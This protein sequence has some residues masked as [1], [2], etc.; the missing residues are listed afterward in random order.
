MGVDSP[1]RLALTR[2]Q[3]CRERDGSVMWGFMDLL[4]FTFCDTA[5]VGQWYKCGIEG[6]K[7]RGERAGALVLR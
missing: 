6:C 5:N 2:T 3:A 4:G 1:L 7:Q